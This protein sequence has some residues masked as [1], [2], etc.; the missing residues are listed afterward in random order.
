[1]Y[2]GRDIDSHL[3]QT[4][5]LTVCGLALS[6]AFLP[7]GTPSGSAG[8]LRKCQ[9]TT[10][11]P[12]AALYGAKNKPLCDS[13]ADALGL[14]PDQRF[15]HAAFLSTRHHLIAAKD[16]LVLARHYARGCKEAELLIEAIGEQAVKATDYLWERRHAKHVPLASI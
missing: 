3:S 10:T 9:M 5:S 6:A 14:P 11:D 12:R 8:L 7:F 16:S 4:A 2:Q 1:M 15:D 13:T